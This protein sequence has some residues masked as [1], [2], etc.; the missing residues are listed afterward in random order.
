M[1]VIVLKNTDHASDHRALRDMK[2]VVQIFDG[3]LAVEA[4]AR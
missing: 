1:R 4:L 3:L 2:G